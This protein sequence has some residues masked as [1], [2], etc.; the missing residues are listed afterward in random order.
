[1][2]LRNQPYI[3]LYVQDYMTDEK[4]NMCSWATQG[5]YIKIM[6][7]LHKQENY[8]S[9]LFK[10]NGKQ[11]RSKELNRVKHFA[12]ILI[13][14]IP[15]TMEDMESAIE[16]LV[17]NGVLDINENMLFQRRMVKDG[18]ISEI[19]SKAGKKGGGNPLLIKQKAKQKGGEN[20]PKNGINEFKQ[21]DKQKPE[22]E[23]EYENEFIN[24]ELKEK[25]DSKEK[26]KTPFDLVVEEWF[27][28]KR[29]R[30]E[31]YKSERSRKA[32]ITSLTSLSG[33]DVETA[34]KIIQQSMANNWAGIFAFKG[35]TK[36]G[37][38]SKVSETIYQNF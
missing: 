7:V 15:C 38:T 8:G 21:K 12:S 33:G 27:A 13:R 28:Y 10:Q 19:R 16:E 4:L 9:I 34:R 18:E 30:K 20:D 11:N 24:R 1:M 25:K 23:Y 14:Q 6:C 35:E 26:E 29:E 2:A 3:P 17:E 5:V 32:F 22:D 31:S 37:A 36:V